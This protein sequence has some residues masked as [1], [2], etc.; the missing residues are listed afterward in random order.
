MPGNWPKNWRV[1]YGMSRNLKHEKFISGQSAIVMPWQRT[2][3][4]WPKGIENRRPKGKS[5]ANEE[6]RPNAVEKWQNVSSANSTV[7]K[8]IWK[9]IR[10][11]NISCFVWNFHQNP[12]SLHQTLTYEQLTKS[13]PRDV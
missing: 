2:N 13:E 12:L 9:M 5:K 4:R 11:K 10:G 6:T 1:G 7:L 8:Q 3:G